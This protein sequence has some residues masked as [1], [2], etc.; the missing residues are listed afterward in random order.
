MF[1]LINFSLQKKSLM[2]AII[3]AGGKSSRLGEGKEKALIKIDRSES[4]NQ[5]R[6]IDLVVENVR[7][8]K[9]EGFLIAI[10]KNTPK[11]AEYYKSQDYELLETPGKGYHADLRYL[12]ARYPEF[13]SVACDIAFLKPEHINSIIDF[14]IH[15]D[16]GRGNSTSITGAVPRD[17]IP[18]SVVPSYVFEHDGRKLVAVG[19]N[20]VTHSRKN[21][22]L[23]FND[24][25]LAININ[26][27]LD[28]EIAKAK[29][30][31]MQ[32]T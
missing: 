15:N 10:S 28:L 22:P 18:P 20:I 26:T 21:L 5:K 30:E 16:F 3:L 14:Y 8:S 2:I 24:P 29:V 11:T 1:S 31:V 13:V 25:L 27:P 4:E 17:I 6:L 32:R 23:V 7:D 19:L 9:A 12:L